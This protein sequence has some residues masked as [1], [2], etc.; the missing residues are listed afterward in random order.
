LTDKTGP[1]HFPGQVRRGGRP[2]RRR[3][4]AGGPSRPSP[5]V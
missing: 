2:Q 3:D 5:G 4:C 1:G